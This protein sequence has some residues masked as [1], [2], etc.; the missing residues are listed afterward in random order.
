MIHQDIHMMTI[1]NVFD[2]STLSILVVSKTGGFYSLFF[3][4]SRRHVYMP[5]ILTVSPFKLNMYENPAFYVSYT[6]EIP[7]TCE[8]FNTNLYHV[9]IT[10]TNSVHYKT[11]DLIRTI[12]RAPQKSSC[13]QHVS[14]VTSVGNERVNKE[15][16][17]LVIAVTQA[18]TNSSRAWHTGTRR[19]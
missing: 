10:S 16:F 5:L 15:H 14:Y 1:A 19:P 2:F 13:I 6:V 9:N 18:V 8:K 4:K 7:F 3:I 11:M 12:P 17:A